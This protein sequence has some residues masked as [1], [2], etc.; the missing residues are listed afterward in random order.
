MLTQSVLIVTC[1]AHAVLVK[2]G[3][4]CM[5]FIPVGLVHLWTKGSLALCLVAARA[6]CWRPRLAGTRQYYLTAIALTNTCNKS[7]FNNIQHE[8]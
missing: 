6:V 4:S 7:T 2:K 3:E 1:Q 8:N 5:R